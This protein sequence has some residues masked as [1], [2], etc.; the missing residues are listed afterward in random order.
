L[1][2]SYQDFHRVDT[3]FAETLDV[4]QQRGIRRLGNPMFFTLDNELRTIL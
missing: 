4:I 1:F 2:R 3:G